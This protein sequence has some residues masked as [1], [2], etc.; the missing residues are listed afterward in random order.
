MEIEGKAQVVCK[1]GS[2]NWIQEQPMTDDSQIECVKCGTKTTRK[3]VLS[4]VRKQVM[5]EA[6]KQLRAGLEGK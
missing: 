4:E 2:T 6:A 1:C 5:K 3:S